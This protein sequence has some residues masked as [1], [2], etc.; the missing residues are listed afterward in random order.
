MNDLIAKTN[1]IVYRD[2]PD[3]VGVEPKVIAP[4]GKAPSFVYVKKVVTEDQIAMTSTLRVKTDMDGEIVSV[5][6][7]K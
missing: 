4:K 6:V 2:Y 1:S 5:S 7:S 3:F